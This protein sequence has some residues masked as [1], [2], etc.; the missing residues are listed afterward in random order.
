MNTKILGDKRKS[1]F[2]D[3]LADVVNKIFDSKPDIVPGTEIVLPDSKF[4]VVD[5]EKPQIDEMTVATLD[6]KLVY[7]KDGYFLGFIKRDNSLV[8]GPYDIVAL[9]ILKDGSLQ[10]PNG[11]KSD[12]TDPIEYLRKNVQPVKEPKF[13][14]SRYKK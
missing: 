4:P 2:D 8:A 10:N 13:H 12:I 14:I 9:V 6:G 7:D 5:L 11:T 3:N 1:N